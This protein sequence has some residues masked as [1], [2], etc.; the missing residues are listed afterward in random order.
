MDQVIIL[1]IILGMGL[2]TYFLKAF[3]IILF[4]S[5]KISNEFLSS[6]QFVPVAVLASLITQFIFFQE[7][8]IDFSFENVFLLASVPTFIISLISK[9]LFLTI[10]FGVLIMCLVRLLM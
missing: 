4:S 8:K 10:F 5:P 6:L 2:V 1:Y 7:S 3:P 9:N